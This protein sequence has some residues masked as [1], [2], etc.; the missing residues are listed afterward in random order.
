MNAGQFSTQG[1]VMD[2]KR[3]GGEMKTPQPGDEPTQSTIN[4]LSTKAGELIKREYFWPMV[5]IVF[6]G[7]L[8]F[9]FLDHMDKGISYKL[10]NSSVDVP[11]YVVILSA[12]LSFGGAFVVLRTT[13]KALNWLALAIVAGVICID[14]FNWGP[15]WQL[16]SGIFRSIAKQLPEPTGFF[17]AF[18]RSYFNAGLTEEGYK[19][20]PTLALL[21]IGLTDWKPWNKRI[22][23]QE[24]LDG[25]MMGIVAGA[26][27]AFIETGFNYFGKEVIK[28]SVTSGLALVTPRLLT[29]LA[30]HIA[31]AGYFGYFIGLAGKF[32]KMRWKLLG[33]GF[34]SAA[35]I[36]ALWN[37]SGYLGSWANIIPAAL[38]LLLL[39]S[40]IM[41]ARELS[42]N[43]A[44]L[45][46]SQILN[47]FSRIRMPIPGAGAPVQAAA[48]QAAAAAPAAAPAAATRAATAAV[49]S[50]AAN[51]ITWADASDTL[52]IQIG[53]ARVPV[54]I[55]ARL[56]ERQTPGATSSKGDG[57]VGEVNANPNDPSI[58]GVRNLSNQ[59]WQVTT[60]T[61]QRRELQP[62]RSIH[63][64]R[65]TRIQ[66][67]D[68]IAAVN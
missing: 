55:G 20:L 38:G 41:K 61:G 5:G 27:F 24:P 35:A 52:V 65:G 54:T 25:I 2:E 31:Y 17:S 33:I 12:F 19:A 43:R 63:L 4:P 68:L 9:Y 26:A 7:L 40:A 13:G 58:L 47:G 57:I 14:L 64:T 59:I 34:A 48:A 67:G 29:D 18:L 42:P 56:Y 62:G 23:I 10:G 49:P 51:S 15:L 45:A 32:P 36:H 53:S 16:S 39:G 66:L 28:G 1:A 46:A 6:V 30:G 11:M 3:P 21:A 60:E 22:G 44:N 37:A 8:L 50:P